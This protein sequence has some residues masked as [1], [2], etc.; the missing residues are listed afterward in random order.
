VE[1]AEVE[2]VVRDRGQGFDPESVPGD[3]KGLAESVHG[4]MA[5][6]GGTA[7]VTSA[8]GEGT[9][10]SLNMPRTVTPSRA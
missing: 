4:R 3:R 10:V 7:T 6:R 9:K 8:P 2:L 5:R 1:P